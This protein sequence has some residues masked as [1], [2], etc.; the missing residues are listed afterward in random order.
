MPALQPPDDTARPFLRHQDLDL[1]HRFEQH[2][3][4][5]FE[6]PAER[7]AGGNLECQRR[8]LILA[9]GGTAQFHTHVHDRITLH[10]PRRGGIQHALLYSLDH[11]GG[12]GHS[13]WEEVGKHQTCTICRWPYRQLHTGILWL[14]SNLTRKGFSDLC[15]T[16]DRF[17]VDDL[18]LAHTHLDVKLIGE[19]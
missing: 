1:H 2:R 7:L 8:A 5:I 12:E 6:R 18:R 17:A 4:G 3:P 15:L 19:P 13:F 11:L 9:P 16:L 14:A 10:N